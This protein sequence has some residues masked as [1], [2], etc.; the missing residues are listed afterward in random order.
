MNISKLLK[1]TALSCIGLFSTNNSIVNAVDGM[2]IDD[3]IEGINSATNNK[4]DT[5]ID[6]DLISGLDRININETDETK[7][8][9]NLL[10]YKAPLYI[11]E[12][13]TKYDLTELVNKVQNFNGIVLSNGNIA[14]Y[15]HNYNRV[16]VFCKEKSSR[17]KKVEQKF[18]FD[19]LLSRSKTIEDLCKH[20]GHDF[21]IYKAFMSDNNNIIVQKYN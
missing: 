1:I 14:Y 20:L 12:Y 10:Y 21:K 16:S 7:K 11:F 9:R 19:Q 15:F 4:L 18:Y 3:D 5:N 2:D 8:I 6:S 13:Y 17:Y